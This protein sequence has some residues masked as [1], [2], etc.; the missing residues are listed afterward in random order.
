M[1]INIATYADGDY[2][3]HACV[4]LASINDVA[5][6]RHKYQIYLF[7]SECEAK[8]IVKTK[9]TIDSFKPSVNVKLINVKFPHT[10]DLPVKRENINSSIYNKMLIYDELPDKIEKIIF[11]DA[12]IVVKTD[13]AELYKIN[14][15][16]NTLGAVREKLYLVDKK[17]DK[18]LKLLNI[19]SYREY[20]NSGV[21]LIDLRKW[22]DEK[23]TQR[24][25][26]FANKY[27]HLTP[28]HDQDALNAVVCGDWESIS[29][30]W[31]PRG[32]NLLEKDEKVFSKEE[33]YK[34]DNYHLIHF[35]GKNKPWLYMSMHKGK[36]IYLKYINTTE[37]REY[38]F[39][40]FSI[41]NVFKKYGNFGKSLFR[42]HLL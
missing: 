12:D 2:M 33:L 26:D 28:M 3:Q 37:F 5:D 29:P 11:F 1:D 39:P 19:N 38:K 22:R 42:K 36:K 14:L 23:I 41:K 7:Y 4:L 13:P 30:L 20:F 32:L 40:D 17:N 31:N 21:L 24:S 6:D 34:S 35:S 25:F 27:G 18:R 16:G 9:K 15:N 10:K 8:N